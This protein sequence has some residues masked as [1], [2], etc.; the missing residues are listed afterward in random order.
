MVSR[1]YPGAEA[2][3]PK[4]GA[5]VER[6]TYLARRRVRAGVILD[7]KAFARP[8]HGGVCARSALDDV[9]GDF[10]NQHDRAAVL[11]MASDDAADG[12]A[13]G[14]PPFDNVRARII[15]RTTARLQWGDPAPLTHHSRSPRQRSCD[16]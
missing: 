8:D 12:E 16:S 15:R 13:H 9:L 4:N 1:G 7:R 11:V 5:V 3:H 2:H 6:G 14:V 10:I